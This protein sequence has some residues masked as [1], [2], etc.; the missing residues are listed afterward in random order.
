MKNRRY[1]RQDC[2]VCGEYAECENGICA[3]CLLEEQ[4]DETAKEDEKEEAE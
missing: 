3:E 4:D 2:D 1:L